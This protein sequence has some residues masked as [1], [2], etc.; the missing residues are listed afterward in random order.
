MHVRNFAFGDELA[1]QAVFYSAVHAIA[2]SD[3]TAAQLDAWAPERP[4]ME[5]W[6]ERMR[7]IRPFVA[8]EDGRITRRMVVSSDTPTF[9]RTATSTTS[10]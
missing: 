4:D 1:L 8:E 9:R 6:T 3:Y 5:R 10:M 2:A 7:A